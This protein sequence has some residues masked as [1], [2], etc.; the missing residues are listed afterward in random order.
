M[1]L[2]L[3]EKG[4]IGIKFKGG[5]GAG[6]GVGVKGPWNAKRVI[7]YNSPSVGDDGSNDIEFGIEHGIEGHGGVVVGISFDP[8][9]NQP[10]RFLLRNSR[11]LGM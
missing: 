6:V 9:G 8:T 11:F 5:V 4:R 2:L 1:S 10:V 7:R 3:N